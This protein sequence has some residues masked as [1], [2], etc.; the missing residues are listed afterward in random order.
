M[1]PIV[2]TP[3]T[4]PGFIIGL[5]SRGALAGLWRTLEYLRI[6]LMT[7]CRSVSLFMGVPTLIVENAFC[8]EIVDIVRLCIC[9]VIVLSLLETGGV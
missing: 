8:G 2:L 5:R 9:G 1:S 7:P 3:T 6:W 4:F